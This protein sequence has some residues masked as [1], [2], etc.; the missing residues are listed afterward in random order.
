MR[1]VSSLEHLANSLKPLAPTVANSQEVPEQF[2][3]RIEPPESLRSRC[4]ESFAVLQS[5]HKLSAHS[6]TKLALTH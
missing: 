2:Q 1:P 4:R 3:S 6:E 5:S